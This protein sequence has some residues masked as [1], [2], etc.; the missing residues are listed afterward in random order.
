MDVCKRQWA[1][2][3]TTV[4]L[5]KSLSLLSDPVNWQK[6]QVLIWCPGPPYSTAPFE[7]SCSRLCHQRPAI[8]HLHW[9]IDCVQRNYFSSGHGAVRLV[10]AADHLSSATADFRECTAARALHNGPCRASM[11][12]PR[13][14]ISHIRRHMDAVSAGTAGNGVEHE[15]RRAAPWSGYLGCAIG[16]GN[17]WT[18]EIPGPGRSKIVKGRA[19]GLLAISCRLIINLV[20]GFYVVIFFFPL[21]CIERNVVVLYML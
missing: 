7:C 10:Y 5:R 12:P 8:D 3:L 1:S 18:Q 16:L 15:L 6:N 2:L 11:Q 21:I 9:L 20:E 13:A 14:R 19:L 4:S 17:Q